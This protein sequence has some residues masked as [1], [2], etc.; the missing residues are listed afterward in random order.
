MQVLCQDFFD[1][2]LHHKVEMITSGMLQ[3]VREDAGLGCP[4]ASFTTNACESLNAVLKRKVNYKKNELPAFVDH[5]KSLIDEQERELERAVIGRGKYRFRREFQYL[6]I[7][8]EVWFRMSRDQ[9]EKHLKKVAHAQI[10]CLENE[11]AVAQSKELPVD[12]KKFQSGLSIPL[13]S[14]Q[15]IWNKAAELISQPNAIVGAPGHARWC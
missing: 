13:P 8:E 7:E 11:T 5:L 15:A 6:Q 3:P 14:V 4:P 9:R 12:P 1:W 10:N 2:F